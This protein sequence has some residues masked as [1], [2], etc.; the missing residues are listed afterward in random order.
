MLSKSRTLLSFKKYIDNFIIIVDFMNHRNYD[1]FKNKIIDYQKEVPT[2]RIEPG[3]SAC[4]SQ[5]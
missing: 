3:A 4:K 5:V 1:R 2:L